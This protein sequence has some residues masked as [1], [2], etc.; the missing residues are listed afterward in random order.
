[1]YPLPSDPNEEAPVKVLGNVPSSEPEEC[2]VRI[3]CIK[4]IDLQ[5]ND[6]TGLVSLKIKI[7]IMHSFHYKSWAVT[8]I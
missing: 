2:V 6:P 5:P 7:G 8:V 3:Y 1:M 4:A